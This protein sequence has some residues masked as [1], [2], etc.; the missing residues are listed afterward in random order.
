MTAESIFLGMKTWSKL[1]R[2]HQWLK[3]LLLM[4]PLLAVDQ[5]ESIDKWFLLL[6]AF[7]SFSL[8]ASSGYVFNDLCGVAEDR[9]HPRK[10]DRP[11]AAGQISWIIGVMGVIGLLIFSF[12]LGFYINN[13]HFVFC[14]LLY[15]IGSFAYSLGLKRVV[16]LDCFIL[17]LLYMLRVIAGAVV[18]EITVSF[19]LLAF[20]L[21]LFLSLAFVKR[22]AELICFALQGEKVQGRGYFAGDAPIIQVMGVVSGY[23]AVLVLAFYF[24]SN[25][26]IALYKLPE[27]VWGAVLAVLFWISWVWLQA[28]R[29]KIGDDPFLFAIKD[30]TSL[31]TGIVFIGVM[32]LAFLG[33]P[34]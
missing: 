25:K 33:L 12:A 3:N 34:W 11:F 29:G 8:S 7:I 10:Q 18:L 24:T 21:L 16:L 32:G 5:M 6:V 31:F 30:K 23:A 14:L 28:H 2:L 9:L 17:A 27:L 19:W 4:V 1:F 15:C 13:D 26:S 22:Y 20:S